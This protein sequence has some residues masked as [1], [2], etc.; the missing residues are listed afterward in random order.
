MSIS[1]MKQD[2]LSRIKPPAILL[3]VFDVRDFGAVPDANGE[4]TSAFQ[5]AIDEAHT[6]GGGQVCVPSGAYVTAALRLKSGVELH[7]ATKD[8]ILRF[9]TQTDEN[10]LPRRVFTLGGHAVL[11]L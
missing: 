1:S 5:A 2:I 11:Q 7:L 8:T 10:A 6:Q 3:C 4:Q 9:S